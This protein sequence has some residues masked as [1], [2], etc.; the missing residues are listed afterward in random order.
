MEKRSIYHGLEFQIMTRSAPYV[1]SYFHY[2]L[3]NFS[4]R[5]S[6]TNVLSYHKFTFTVANNKGGIGTYDKC[7]T[8][9]TV[10]GYLGST[11]ES[12]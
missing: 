10:K 2:M 8:E 3:Q 1:S 7:H 11:V 9:I 5:S 6:V 4:S 12:R